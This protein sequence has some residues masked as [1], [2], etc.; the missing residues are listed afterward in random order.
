MLSN[1]SVREVLIGIL[2]WPPFY[3]GRETSGFAEPFIRR[4]VQA[5]N[6][7]WRSDP[8]EEIA[9]I[10]QA[11]SGLVADPPEYDLVFGLY[12]TSYRREQGLDFIPVPGL[13]IELGAIAARPLTWRQV[14]DPPEQ[15]PHALVLKEEAGFHLLRG[16]CDYKERL[17]ITVADNHDYRRLAAQLIWLWKKYR[18]RDVLLVVDANTCKR[19]L[20]EIADRERWLPFWREYADHGAEPPVVAEV[21][22]FSMV[23][24]GQDSS[25]VPR[26]PVCIA[27]RSDSPRFRELLTAAMRADL[28]NHARLATARLYQ[29]LR[30][31]PGAE[32]LKFDGSTF[33]QLGEDCWKRFDE[34]WRE[35]LAHVPRRDGGGADV[36]PWEPRPPWE[37]EHVQSS[38]QSR[39][40]V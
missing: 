16:A 12:D 36:P 1:E 40:K 33:Q 7:Y 24:G 20:A 14:I 31:T 10:D 32:H 34:A 22:D 25:W 6:P 8:I 18:S 35:V 3:E 37:A 21:R 15:K 28:F 2:N 4:L 19:V 5:V 11:I 9:T 26:F 29:R 17:D 38:K 30:E 13:F 39:R 23:G 27:V